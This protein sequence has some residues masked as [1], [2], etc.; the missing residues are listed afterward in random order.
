MSNEEILAWVAIGHVVCVMV[1]FIWVVNSDGLI[2][3]GAINITFE[4]ML[5]YSIMALMWPLVGLIL[6]LDHT[7]DHGITIRFWPSREKK[8]KKEKE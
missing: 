5:G 6:Y 2:N 8:I 4:E 1:F 3:D 7:K